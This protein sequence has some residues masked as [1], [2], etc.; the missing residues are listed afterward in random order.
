LEVWQAARRLTQ[1]IYLLGNKGKLSQDFGLRDQLRRAAVS[2]MS[3]I[4]EGFDRETDRDFVRFL[5]IAKASAA[6]VRAQLYVVE[7]VGYA[8]QETASQLR[9]EH[10]I[11]SRRLSALMKHLKS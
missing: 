5:S 4:A 3:N 10:E 8:D 1:E 11:V 9:Q 7:D 6:E 2:V